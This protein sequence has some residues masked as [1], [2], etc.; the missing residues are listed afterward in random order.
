MTNP[1]PKPVFKTEVYNA[2]QI[3]EYQIGFDMEEFDCPDCDG[4]GEVTEEYEWGEETSE[5]DSCGG[6]GHF[7]VRVNNP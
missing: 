2:Y 5:C 4:C 6:S 1:I 3:E 7:Y